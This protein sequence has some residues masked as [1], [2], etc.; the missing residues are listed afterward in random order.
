MKQKLLF[1]PHDCSCKPT[2]SVFSPYPEWTLE[3]KSHELFFSP[4]TQVISPLA[5]LS[6]RH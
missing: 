1:F 6:Y 2:I 3:G 5:I 4:V